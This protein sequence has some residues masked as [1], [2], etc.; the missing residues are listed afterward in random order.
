MPKELVLHLGL[1][2]T[3]STSI[4]RS[5]HLNRALLQ[6]HGITYPVIHSGESGFRSNHS[7]PMYS[8]FTSQPHRYTKH[9][10]TGRDAATVNLHYRKSL[11]EVLARS[12]AEFFAFRQACRQAGG[13]VEHFLGLL[14]IDEVSAFQ[15]VHSNA[16]PSNHAVRLMMSIN[17]Y[18]PAVID[19]KKNP[20]RHPR[21]LKLLE[22][23]T[24]AKFFLT[25]QELNDTK[26]SRDQLNDWLAA[27]LGPEFCD[28]DGAG[29]PAEIFWSDQQLNVLETL[30]PDLPG[31]FMAPVHDYLQNSA[32]LTETQ[33]K[34]MSSVCLRLIE[35][36]H[37][38]AALSSG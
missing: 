38:P 19:G 30:L 32:G 12:S 5:C 33:R 25:Q 22:M 23:I 28:E 31:R 29:S 4:Q 10:V 1:H 2:K 20:A 17:Q 13:P 16:S 7:I 26:N 37:H 6:E 21:D 34:R 8:L 36:D 15:I 18:Y 27:N 35:S 9:I 14:G 3:G 11:D 24:G